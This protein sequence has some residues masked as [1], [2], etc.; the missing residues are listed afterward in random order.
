MC[1]NIVL[2]S[3]VWGILAWMSA[4]VV[5]QQGKPSDNLPNVLILGD[6]ISMGYMSTVKKQL[7]VVDGPLTELASLI[8]LIIL[9]IW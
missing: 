7:K 8:L 3:I 2:S 5:G 1:K 6:S 9:T 4:N